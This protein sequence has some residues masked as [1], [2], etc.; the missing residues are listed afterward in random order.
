MG[1]IREIVQTAESRERVS[2]WEEL[3]K[4]IREDYNFLAAEHTDTVFNVIRAITGQTGTTV[5]EAMNILE[6]A[7]RILLEYQ[8]IC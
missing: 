1:E 5:L 4:D 2:S 3:F 7:R 8:T 6:D